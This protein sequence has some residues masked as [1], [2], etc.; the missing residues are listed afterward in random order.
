MNR[1]VVMLAIIVAATLAGCGDESR[2]RARDLST[3]I[4]VTVATA[5]RVAESAQEEFMGT[6]VARNRADLEPKIQA[7]VD[8]ILV[9][10][11]SRVKAGD[12]LAELDAREFEARV[13]QARAVFEQTSQDM[14]RFENLLSQQAATQQEY[15]G[16]KA[17]TTVAEAGLA[18]AE[19][20]LSYTR[21]VAPFSG[22]VTNKMIDIGDL[23]VP[24][25]PMFTLEEEATLRFVA[26]LPE[27]RLGSIA[28][29]DSLTILVSNVTAPVR[30]RVEEVSPSADPV[31][32]SFAVKIALPNTPGVRPGQFGRLLLPAGGDETIFIPRSA[33]VRRGQLDLVYVV[34]PDHKAMLRLV[35]IG[36]QYPDR[37]EILSGLRENEKV[38]ISDQ[39]DLADGDLVEE[40]P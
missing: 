36:R 27:S 1:Y 35:L 19:T 25:R 7:R 32:R 33:L 6:V 21:I 23:A 2:E 15:D 26:T 30:G 17:R 3:P 39:R 20:A 37:L 5:E 29:G 22:K 12:V 18:E 24:G 38:V 13:Q 28:Y 11:G 9:S 8:R 31:S 40:M 4:K 34:T 10:L 14:T 16:I